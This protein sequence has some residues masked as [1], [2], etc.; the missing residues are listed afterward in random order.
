MSVC[1]KYLRAVEEDAS[2]C[3]GDGGAGLRLR[4]RC[5]WGL[6]D[7][8]KLKSLGGLGVYFCFEPQNSAERPPKPQKKIGPEPNCVTDLCVAKLKINP[9]LKAIVV[10]LACDWD[11]VRADSNGEMEIVDSFY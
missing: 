1:V 7:D 3:L 2:G 5:P 10:S 9:K 4:G 11:K 6:D 8:E